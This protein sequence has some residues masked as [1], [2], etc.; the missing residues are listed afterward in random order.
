M[1]KRGFI[2]LTGYCLPSQGWN[3]EAG[4]EKGHGLRPLMTHFFWLAQLYFLDSLGPFAQEWY[5]LQGSAHIISNPGTVPQTWPHANLMVGIPQLRFA[6]FPCSPNICSVG[7]SN[8][9]N[10]HLA[11]SAPKFMTFLHQ[12]FHLR[13]QVCT[14]TSRQDRFMKDFLGLIIKHLC[15]IIQYLSMHPQILFHVN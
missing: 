2:R 13:L 9:E 1:G 14:T 12:T 6:L 3:L 7:D 11:Q 15:G 8:K 4:T 10:S 5:H